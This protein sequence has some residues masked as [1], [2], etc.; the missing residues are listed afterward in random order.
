MQV[1]KRITP[2]V[3]VEDSDEVMDVVI[4]RLVQLQVGE[5]LG[6]PRAGPSRY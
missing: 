2:V 4:D 3:D 1:P 6:R 5:S